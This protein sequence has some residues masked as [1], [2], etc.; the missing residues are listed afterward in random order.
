GKGDYQLLDAVWYVALTVPRRCYVLFSMAVLLGSLVGLGS[1]ASHSEF[2][3]MRAAGVSNRRIL[4]SAAMA[5]IG[6]SVLMLGFG[7]VIAPLSERKAQQLRTERVEGRVAVQGK[8]G[9][10]VRNAN[11]YVNVK[12]L[13]PGMHLQ[14]VTIYDFSAPQGMVATFARAGQYRDGVW[15]LHDIE[16]SRVSDEGVQ[17]E[18]VARESWETLVDPTLFD[19]LLVDPDSLSIVDLGNY[20]NH[21]QRND[22][23][24]RRYELG[25]W[26]KLV[27]PITTFIMLMIA[28][29]FVFGDHRS[30]GTGHRLLIGCLIG[31]V[32][33]LAD[34]LFAYVGL[35]YGGISPLISAFLPPLAF[36]LAAVLL[37]R[38]V[39]R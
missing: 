23:D 5:G 3:V 16:R 17:R 39:V 13:L 26:R 15:E 28:V 6:L 7:E 33:F 38:R 18:R 9:L 1:L 2:I 34:R 29:P 14:D 24:A 30:T 32:Y 35:I 8:D 22:L 10:W 4:W 27:A 20:I 12:K 37:L 11:R 21:L 19:V 25:F 31:I 36:A